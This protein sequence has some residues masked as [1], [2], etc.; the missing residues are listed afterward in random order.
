V[1]NLSTFFDTTEEHDIKTKEIV[2]NMN[3]LKSLTVEEYTLYKKWEDINYNFNQEVA[4]LRLIKSNIWK[5]TNLDDESITVSEIE[6]LK[7]KIV[8]IDSTNLYDWNMIRSFCHTMTFD[9]NIGRNLK[10]LVTDENTNKVMGCLTI[11]SD[12]IAIKAR[13]EL[14]GWTK[15]NR[16]DNKKLNH[17][18]IGTCIMA[19][20]PFGYNFL[21]GKLMAVL[22]TSKVVRDLWEKKYEDKLVG[23]TTTSLYGSYSMYNSIPYWKSAGSTAGRITLKPDDKFYKYWHRYIKEKYIDNYNKA[24]NADNAIGVTSGIKQKIMSMILKEVGLTI[25][26]YQH[27]YERGVYFAPIYQNAYEFL[28]NEIEQDKLVLTHRYESDTN[29]MLDW[30]KKKAV[31]R[32]RKLKQGSRLNRSVLFYD[33]LVGV[34]WKEAKKKYI[35]Q[36]GR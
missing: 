13:D 22:I 10:F 12:V 21:G 29:G 28:R 30:W 27:G 16:L 36:V 32:Y 14:I 1:N 19:T 3:F 31:K 5:P 26:H 11:G 35:E 15:E 8:P 34:T 9:A 2:D 17:T 33:D 7:P 20:Q 24:Y 6:N 23:L 18:A 25:S 4:N